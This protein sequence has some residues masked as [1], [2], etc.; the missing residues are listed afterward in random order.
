MIIELI[1]DLLK[2]EKNCE[3]STKAYKRTKKLL[4]I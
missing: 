2:C 1:S 4:Q 3:E